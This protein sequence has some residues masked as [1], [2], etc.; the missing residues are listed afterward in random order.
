M[1]SRAILE[2]WLDGAV[3][4]VRAQRRVRVAA[5]LAAVLLVLGAAHVTTVRL[6]ASPPVVEALRAFWLL[7]AVFAIVAAGAGLLS[8]PRR[9]AVAAAADR[10]AGL[11]DELASAHWF[12]A[13]GLASPWIDAHLARAATT[14]G[15][16]TT[17]ALFPLVVPRRAVVVGC[18]ALVVAL[19]AGTWPRPTAREAESPLVAGERAMPGLATERTPGAAGEDDAG[20]VTGAASKRVAE[21]WKQVGDLA[22]GLAPDAGGKSL[23]EA[24]AARDARA[25]AQVL[26]VS[27]DDKAEAVGAAGGESPGEQMS[28][29]L[30]QGILERLSALIKAE[31][32][33]PRPAAADEAA[34]RPTA[35]LDSELRADSPD[36]QRAARREQ[37]TGEAGLNTSLRALSRTSADGRDRVRGEADAVDGAGRANLGGGAMGRRVGTSTGGAGDGDQPVGALVAPEADD[38]VLGRKT[39]RLAVQL[40]AVR[41]RQ[42]DRDDADAPSGAE[43]AFYAATRAQAAR[44]DF[45]SATTAAR[46]AEAAAPLSERAPLEYRAAVKRYTLAR[47]RREPAA[48]GGGAAAP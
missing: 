1:E 27:R 37:S 39:E 36:A 5:W 31:A 42:E 38:A 13:S 22:A 40:Q 24:I 8:R 18:A 14:T 32:D 16:L 48:A 10:R 21:L 33:A 3:A 11:R 28:D 23:A 35:R 25:A 17:G 15:S 20:E 26:R 46:T 30:A 7:A 6:I 43:E 41:S 45:V 44:V 2:A 9:A 34:E 47:H 29:V 12:G 19:A 4:R